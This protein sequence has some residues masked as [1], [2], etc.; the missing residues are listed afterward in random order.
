MSRD[1]NGYN[2]FGLPFS[3]DGQVAELTANVAETFTAPT[4]YPCWIA[5]FSYTPGASIYVD[6]INTA[7]VPSGGAALSTSR[8]NPVACEVR[9]GQQISIITADNNTPVVQVSYYF[10]DEY[11]N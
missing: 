3:L 10:K 1:V 2:G 6:G 8:L 5:I 7:V 9:S 11:I 4:N